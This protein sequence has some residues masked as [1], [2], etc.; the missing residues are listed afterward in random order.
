MASRLL[1]AGHALTI[2]DADSAA[3][4]R[5]RA[6]GGEPV[7]S[8]AEVAR[9]AEVVFT[10]LPS[11]AALEDVVRGPAGLVTALGPG[12]TIVDVGTTDIRVTRS[13]ASAVLKAGGDYLD[14]PVSGSVMRAADGTLTFM[15]GGDAAVLE[16]VRPFLDRLGDRVI[17][18]GPTGNG[19]LAKLCNNMLC[20]ANLAAIAETFVTGVKSGL[21]AEVLLDVV[22]SSS[23]GSWL[24]ESWVA[25]TAFAGDYAPRF[26][27]DLMHKDVSLF[28]AGAAEADVAAPV[29]AATREMFR[30]ARVKGL[31]DGD[32]TGLIRLYEDLAGVALLE[33]SEPST[34]KAVVA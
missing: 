1:V 10:C 23:G 14:A 2:A 17:H 21:D 28:A 13:L 12:T 25:E 19:Q 22:R 34:R 9:R 5:G 33:G 26:K 15:V 20:A 4:E 16:R 31:G 27:L 29:C 8:A 32:M 24:L 30:A 11:A 18:C 7:G 6:A 3:L